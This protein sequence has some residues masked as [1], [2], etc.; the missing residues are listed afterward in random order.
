MRISQVHGLAPSRGVDSGPKSGGRGDF[1]T[2]T[3]TALA[4]GG[5]KAGQPL[6]YE[7]RAA[8]KAVNAIDSL[9]R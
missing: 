2:F 1:I 5:Y 6:A 9:A 4:T 7:G 8:S 3:A